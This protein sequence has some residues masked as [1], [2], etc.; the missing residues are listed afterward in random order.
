[1]ALTR[2]SSRACC[3]AARMSSTI[4]S[5]TVPGSEELI[6]PRMVMTAILSVVP[7]APRCSRISRKRGIGSASRIPPT[8]S[9]AATINTRLKNKLAQSATNKKM[10]RQPSL[11]FAAMTGRNCRRTAARTRAFRVR[12]SHEFRL[13]RVS[14]ADE[15]VLAIASFNASIDHACPL[16]RLQIFEQLLLVL[17]RQLDAV[18]V[19]FVAIAF[20]RRVEKRIR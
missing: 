20:F 6:R 10:L 7:R 19:S 17:L 5:L 18:G 4:E 16:E 14:R 1:M 11:R 3:S 13:A 15:R 12:T 9:N 2:L 8:R